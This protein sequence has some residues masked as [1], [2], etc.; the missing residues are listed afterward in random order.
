[1]PTIWPSGARQQF[2]SEAIK[3]GV[4]TA[5]AGLAQ[6]VRDGIYR[7]LGIRANLAEV[8][9]AASGTDSFLI[10][11]GLTRLISDSPITT[12][13]VGVEESGSGV[14]LA[15]QERHFADD[16]ALS[17]TVHKGQPLSTG[18]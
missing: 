3:N 9:I 7:Q 8:V 4:Q 17:Y 1:M 13:I 10:A 11:Q 15:L 18:K 5:V 12:I 14:K 16:T 2:I 6:E